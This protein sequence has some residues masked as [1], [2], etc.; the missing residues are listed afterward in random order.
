MN[1]SALKS[2][3]RDERGTHPQGLALRVHRAL[4]WLDRAEQCTDDDGRFI[5]LWISFNSAYSQKFDD[6]EYIFFRGLSN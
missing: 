4:S 6:E 2:R 3:Q 5:F 1:Y